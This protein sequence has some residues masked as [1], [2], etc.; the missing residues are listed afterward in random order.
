MHRLL[1]RQLRHQLGKDF[2]PDEALASFLNIVDSY[3]HEV[4]KEQRLLQNA[5]SMNTAELNAVN[6]RNRLQNTEMTRTLLN[7]LSDGV[8]ATDLEGRLTF[9]NAAAEKKLGWQESE[10]IGQLMHERMGCLY[11]DGLPLPAGNCPH[12]RVIRDG[13]SVQ[14]N[15]LFAGRDGALIPVEYRSSPV[16]QDGRISGALVS[17]QDTSVHIEAANKLHQANERLRATLREL[18]FQQ[19]ALD[20][21]AIVSIA[22]SVGR[23]I[24]VNRKFSEI[25]QY[26]PEEL[27]G[28]DHRMLNSGYHPQSF[29]R[30]MWRVM[31]CGQVW[32]GEI[33]NR[34]KDGSFYW[35]ESTIVPFMDD[36]GRPERYI[37]VRT[38]ITARKLMEA[39]MSEQRAFYERISETMGEGIYVQDAAGR[40]TYLNSEAEHLLGWTRE[41]FIGM[42]VHNTIHM[43][44]AQGVPLS[45]ENCPIHLAVDAHG[46]WHGDDQVF[47][48]RDGT[49]FPVEATSRAILRDGV[50]HGS[51]VAFSD[52]TERKSNEQFVLMAQERLNLALEGSGLA[53]WDWDIATDRVYLSDRWSLMMGGEQQDVVLSS[54]Q[55]FGMVHPDERQTIEASLI[56]VLRGQTEFYSVEFRVQ[57]RDGKWVWIHTHGKVVERS[58]DGRVARMTGTNADVTERREAEEAL[59]LA[60]E[61]AEAASRAKGDFL[62]NMSHEIRTPMNGIIGMTE[63]ALD[64]E[65][66][67]E[68]REYLVLVQSSAD[69][70]LTI[71]NDILDFSKIESGKLEIE[72]IE[73]SLEHMLR[74]TMKSLAVRA[75]EKQLELL[76]HVASDVPDRLSGDPGRLRQ[77]VVNLVGN[78]IKFTATGEVE[79]NVRQMPNAPEGC[80]R[81]H[82]SVRDTG[83]G[84][85]REKFQTIFESFSQADTSTTRRY[86]GTGLGLTISAQLVHLMGG[87]IGLDSIV[88]HG[89]N[90]HFTL[91][92][93]MLSGSPLA[94][95][96]HT[97]SIA[98]LSVLIADDNATNCRLLQE[99]LSNWKMLPVV[100]T[101][102]QEALAELDRAASAGKPYG[103]ALLDLQMPDMDGFELIERIRRHPEYAVKTMMM[104]TSEGQRGHAARCRELGV[105]AYLMK[106]VSQSEMFDAIMTALGVSDCAVPLTTRH[107]LKEM[108]RRLNLLLAEDNAVNQTLAVRLLEK[109]GHTVSVANNGL[110]AVEQWQNGKFDAILMD[111]DMPLMNGYQATQRIRELEAGTGTHIRIVAMTAHAMQGAREECLSYGMDGYLAKPIDTEALWHELDSLVQRTESVIEPVVAAADFDQAMQIMDGDRELFGEIAALFLT[112][113]PPHMQL[114]RDGL[115][116]GDADVVR[117]NAHTLKGMA[118]IFAAERTLQAALRVEQLA[119]QSDCPDAVTELDDALSELI[120]AIKAYLG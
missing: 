62:A 41:E 61:A 12:L 114:I 25:S 110:E 66:T 104:L 87:Q 75:H 32:H 38:D 86:G 27:A 15:G 24:Y 109:L 4:D 26:T 92:L 113:A 1:E 37:S 45:A 10:L 100:T 17:F 19:K 120:A 28:H 30:E 65:L 44:T 8:Y 49:P 106:P 23:I 56:A 36:L 69:A 98:G 116:H 29:F 39:Q 70:L 16:M 102:G 18:E 118:G 40:C 105:A 51:V 50:S 22:D 68:Q 117:R 13:V 84:I 42:P 79:M 3:Y 77:V 72:T 103:L 33:R 14:D 107:S 88:G 115:A 95:Y 112:D 73:F 20:E 119:G 57:R 85:P 97:G 83:I 99:M 80:V 74:E 71:L 35:V 63:L 11:S 31:E 93:P 5:L 78:A 82:F 48:R 43:V 111:V 21:H 96:Q 76:L 53:L 67:Q 6:E 108:R 94:D 7:T 91:D 58:A 101:N 89:S 52:I 90:F 59:R 81:L 9:M 55:L 34:R 60:K 64:T 46:E 2:Q 47:R 54:A